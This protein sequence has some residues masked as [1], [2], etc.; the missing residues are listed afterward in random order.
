M[1]K[2]ALDCRMIGSGGIGSYFESLL[3]YFVKNYEC[4]FVCYEKNKNEL[5]QFVNNQNIE[6]SF[7][8]IKTF[9]LREMFL[10]PQKIIEK[11]NE[12]DFYYTPYC[13]IPH[14]LLKK[15]KIPIFTTIHDVI[16]LDIKGLTGKFG[17]KIRKFVYQNAINK[18]KCVFTVSQFSKKRIEQNLHTKNKKIVV[19][20]N[21]VPYWFL[22]N[23][24][25]ISK[26]DFILFVGNIK[27]HKGLSVL[28]NAYKI[29]LEKKFITKLVIV[30]NEKNF[31]T[32]DNL[33]S[34]KINEF[35]ANSIEFTQKITNEQLK[36]IY[37]KAKLLIQPSFYEGFGMPPLEALNCG[38]N[39]ILSDIEIFTE[40]Y[41]DFPV[42]FFQTG[43]SNDLAQKI[44]EN[45]YKNPPQS[46]PQ[47][48]SFDKTFDIIQSE[49]KK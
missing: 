2:I 21:S 13:N 4:F 15:I 7:C 23:Q 6:F 9:S 37:L 42:T 38:T 33:I 14:N 36:E 43:N 39:V 19:T 5:N 20:Y 34:K 45:Y 3:P 25:K 44:I 49:L 18:S 24:K 41:K 26:E 32:G 10:F 28:L 8:E 47:K 16:F 40:I 30:G 29:L 27:Q 17:T 48:Y 46:F 35:P 22:E 31:R 1:Y 11:I 12:C